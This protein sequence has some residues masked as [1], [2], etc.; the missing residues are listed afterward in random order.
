ANLYVIVNGKLAM[1]PEETPINTVKIMMDSFSAQLTYK[2]RDALTLTLALAHRD[3]MH[4]R[5]TNIPTDYPS[6]NFLDFHR[7]HLRRLFDYGEACAKQG[8]L[9]TNAEQSIRHN[10]HR[11]PNEAAMR[12]ACPAAMLQASH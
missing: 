2:N 10:L 8:L 4:F 5:L 11:Y 7:A 6:G 1:Q 12:T 9:W 3:H